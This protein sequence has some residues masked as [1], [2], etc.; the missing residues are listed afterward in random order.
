MATVDISNAY[1]AVNIHPAWRERKG[2]SWDFREGVVNRR[3]NH[4]CMG[5]S[6]SPFMFSKIS[7][8]V[9]RCMVREG[10]DECVN[11]LDDFCMVSRSQVGCI[12]AQHTLVSILRML[13]FYISFRKLPPP[14]PTSY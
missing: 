2:L 11:Y 9:V 4:L 5:L 1:W 8:F 14:P 12:M 3:D 7:D 10:F 13:G 6:S